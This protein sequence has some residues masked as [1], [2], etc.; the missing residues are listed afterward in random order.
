M[1][2]DL[3]KNYRGVNFWEKRDK[4][5][6]FCFTGVAEQFALAEAAMNVWSMND[7]LEQPS[8]SLQGLIMHKD[9]LCLKSAFNLLQT[10][11]IIFVWLQVLK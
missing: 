4:M 2:A 9:H 3:V 10:L 7:S 6:V 8:T 11:K 1:V 5:S